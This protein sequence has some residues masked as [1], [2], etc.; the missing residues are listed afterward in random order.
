VRRRL[1]KKA[2][3]KRTSKPIY[4]PGTGF[5]SLKNICGEGLVIVT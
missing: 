1:F 2:F 5:S 4:W 3:D